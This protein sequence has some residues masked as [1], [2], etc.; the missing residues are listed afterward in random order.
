MACD[1]TLL[2]WFPSAD[3]A[4]E[5]ASLDAASYGDRA[6]SVRSWIR[7]LQLPS[8]VVVAVGKQ[9]LEPIGVV[10][11]EKAPHTRDCAQLLRLA[12]LPGE[13]GHGIGSLLVEAVGSENKLK[14]QLR[15]RS[16]G[17]LEFAKAVGFRAV[18]LS[19]GRFGDCDGIDLER[20]ATATADS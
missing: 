12:V 11:V 13:R 5:L 4:T 2:M 6:L 18:G 10:A 16:A 15:E 7:L 9:Y 1:Q 19:R 14:L 20:P 8:S 3:E 17:A